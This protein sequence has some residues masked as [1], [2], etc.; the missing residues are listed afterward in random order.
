MRKLFK[1]LRRGFAPERSS[2]KDRLTFGDVGFHGDRYLLDLVDT[3]MARCD[4]FVETGS[5]V[6]STLAYVARRF[7]SAQCYSCEPDATA[8]GHAQDNTRG[9][10]NVHLFNE[11]SQSFM[12]RMLDVKAQGSGGDALFWL[13]AHDY[14]FE[15]PLRYEVETV[16]THWDKAFIL[17]DDF[18]VP[19]LDCFG[20]D[21]YKGQA[22]S[23]DFIEDSLNR[24]HSYYLYYP[25]Y[26]DRTSEF[27]PLRGWGL[28]EFGH[29]DTFALPAGLTGRVSRTPIAF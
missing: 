24:K 3:L 2:S 17:V 25:T 26:T 27:H 23:F 6:G 1:A 14:G 19:G 13:D 28:I 11:M 8:Y 29:G 12:Q 20:Y 4:A 15:W 22:C 16:T 18:K 5:N 9:L 7:P 10:G 21:Q